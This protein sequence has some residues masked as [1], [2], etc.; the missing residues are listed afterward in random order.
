[1]NAIN[2]AVGDKFDPNRQEALYRQPLADG[3][4]EDT[5]AAVTK[6]GYTLHDRTLRP[7][8]VGVFKS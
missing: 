7:A 2:P 8:L 4:S 3:A 6:I 5:V 1:M